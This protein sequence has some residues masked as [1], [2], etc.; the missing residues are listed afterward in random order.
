MTTFKR[1]INT[2]LLPDDIFSYTDTKFYDVVKR[3]VGES[4]A[5]LLEIQS[6]RST[7]LLLQ[8]PDVFAI[9]N[10]KCSALNSLKEKICLRTDDDLYIVKPGIKSLVNYFYELI[11]KKQDENIK[12]FRK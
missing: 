1:C 3:I 11:I 6:I 8:I 9:L 5:D 7:D 4:A 2:S 10:I 12:L